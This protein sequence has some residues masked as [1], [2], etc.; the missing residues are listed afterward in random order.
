M[1]PNRGLDSYAAEASDT[2]T[3]SKRRGGQK[4]ICE[5]VSGFHQSGRET[6]QAPRKIHRQKDCSCY[7]ISHGRRR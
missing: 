1:K 7:R 6:S 4:Q 3:A 5:I 2:G